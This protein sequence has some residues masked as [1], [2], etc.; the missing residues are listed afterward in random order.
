[1]SRPALVPAARSAVPGPP[2]DVDVVVVGAGVVGAATAWQ[3]ASRGVE[4]LLVDRFGPGHNRGASHGTSRIYRQTYVAAPYL[5]LAVEA[6]EL[7]RCL[8]DVTGAALLQVTGGVDHGDRSATTA[9]AG[10][11]AAH[12]IAHHW[13]D[14]QQARERWPGMRFSGPVL[15]QP[16]RSGRLH[17]DQAVAALT[18]AAVG[19]GARLRH[20]TTVER[21]SVRGTDR[22]DVETS[23]GRIRAR[24]AV[25]AAGAWSTGLLD[26]LVDLPPLRVT[27]EQPAHFPVRGDDPCGPVGRT[28]PAWPTFV[29]HTGPAD[30]WPSGVYGL[31]APAHGVKVGFHGV[32][33]VCDPDRRTFTAEPGLLHRLQDYV[34]RHLPGLDADHPEPVSCTYTSTPD[35]GFFLRAHGPLVVAAGFSGHG[36]KFAPALGR[37]L[38]D[39]AAGAA[40]ESPLAAVG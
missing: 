16:D 7:W 11:L 5:R 6:F 26:G 3:L 34:A 38:A 28:G 2:S 22:V 19:S 10:S 14:P 27:Q 32:G 17:A 25:V 39:L 24:R 8:E 35:S 15:V 30:G 9:L 21:L 37:V 36:F 18:A 13:L 29:H 20:H 12:G 1:M 4:V 33:P 40:T 23:Q 31:A